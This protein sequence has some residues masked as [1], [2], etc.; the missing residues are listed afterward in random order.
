M[1]VS[2]E[3]FKKEPH[4]NKLNVMLS[5]VTHKASHLGQ[6]D[7]ELRPCADH[8]LP[9]G[10]PMQALAHGDRDRFRSHHGIPADQPIALY[11]GRVAH[12]KNIGFLLEVLARARESVPTLQLVIAGEGPAEASLKRSLAERGL[13]QAVRFIGYLDRAQELPDCYAAADVFVFASRTETQGLVLLEAMAAG[14]PVLALACMG[15]RSILAPERGARIAP[16]DI[17]GFAK[18]LCDLLANPELQK[19]LSREGRAYAQEWSDQAMAAKLAGLYRRLTAARK[20]NRK[21]FN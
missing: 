14:L 5:R 2:E 1:I 12:E 8:A 10:I 17:A 11:V 7:L 9:T 4:R 20:A 3:D 21:D 15:T 18:Q 6:I 16:D 19:R 13:S